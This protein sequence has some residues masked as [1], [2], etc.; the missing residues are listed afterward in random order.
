MAD[1]GG[2]PGENWRVKTAE[3][4]LA[5]LQKELESY[6]GRLKYT[7]VSPGSKQ[8]RRKASKK[9]TKKMASIRTK[10]A[11][12]E[13]VLQEAKRARIIAQEDDTD[14]QEMLMEATMNRGR[15]TSK[16][17]KAQAII[18]QR[19]AAGSQESLMRLGDPETSDN[20][21]A[22]EQSSDSEGE[23]SHKIS[24]QSQPV[25]P[26][27]MRNA[28]RS[29]QGRK[30]RAQKARKDSEEVDVQKHLDFEIPCAMDQVEVSCVA[31][32]ANV[33]NEIQHSRSVA[34]ALAFGV[35]LVALGLLLQQAHHDAQEQVSRDVEERQAWQQA[36]RDSEQALRASEQALRD[37]EERERLM[38]TEELRKGAAS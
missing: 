31:V 16:A 9:R 35:A 24:E 33:T 2:L 13:V 14:Y 21:S 36:L 22:N 23:Q 11:E 17:E 4:E 29:S 34:L 32:P 20:D 28:R 7:K 37:V 8:G 12:A 19:R 26:G 18:N 6:G 10:M 30:R 15:A 3:N 25:S 38:E 27:V 5:E 1:G